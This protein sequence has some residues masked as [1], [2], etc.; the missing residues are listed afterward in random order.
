M[1]GCGCK[2]QKCLRTFAGVNV[3]LRAAV[4]LA[5]MRQHA[6]RP[7]RFERSEETH[8]IEAE[9]GDVLEVDGELRVGVREVLQLEAL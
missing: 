9:A 8:Q 7:R 6:L 3:A 1:Y 5:H 4:G 2:T